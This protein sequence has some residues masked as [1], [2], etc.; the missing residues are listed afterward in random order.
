MTR[1]PC[2][3]TEN[4]HIFYTNCNGIS[5]KLSEI[6]VISQ[7]RNIGAICTTESHLTNEIFDAEISLPNFDVFR[8]DRA[9]NEKGG[10]SV[11][12]VRK[13]FSA[14]KLNWFHGTES[15][16]VK[17]HLPSSV[18]Y[19]VCVYRSPSHRTIEANQ[20]L[21]SQLANIPVECEKN[22]IVVGDINLPKVDWKQGIVIKPE[23]ST[24]KWLNMQSEFLD[25]FITK[26]FSWF[27]EEQKTRIRNVNGSLQQS[28]LDQVFTNNTGLVNNVEITA[29]LGKSDHVSMMVEV[30]SAINLDYVTT[31]R[32]NWYKVNKEFVATNANKINWG[33][34]GNI[35]NVESMWGELYHKILSISDLV[36][37]VNIKTDKSGDI[38]EKLPWDTSRL[39][40]KRKEKDQTWRE[41]DGNPSMQ[42]FQ[43][44]MYKQSEFQK[45]EFQEKLKYEKKIVSGLKLN[46]KPFFR[47]LRSK[48][49]LRKTVNELVDEDGNKT[50]SPNDTAEVLLNFFQSVF[51]GESFGPLPEKCFLD[52][53][54]TGKVMENL[55]INPDQVKKL[56]QK[57]N[58][59]KAI[60][61][62]GLHPK[63]LKYL[64][65]DDNFV[66]ALT[67]L[68]KR[69]VMEECIPEIWKTAVVIPIHK[70]GS[71]H[72]PENYRP[73]SLTCILCKLYETILREHILAFVLGLITDKQHGFLN[74]K[75]CL[76]NL[77][78]TL[79]KA[80]EYM[81]EGNCV[82][83]LYFDFSKAFD[84]VSHYRLLVKLQT[85]GVSEN[86]LNIIRNFLGNRTM[87]VRVGDAVSSAKLVTSG[88]PQ[89]SVLGPILFLLFINDLPDNILSMI[90]I[91]ADD[92]KMIVDPFNFEQTN[93]DLEELQMW[94][95]LWVLNFNIEKCKV[96]HIGKSN[97]LNPYK[98]LDA[99]LFTC[100]N[101][102]DLGVIFNNR[103]NFQDHIRTA[104]SK[105][106]S[107]L[108]WLLRNTLSR[109]T[110]V[111]KTA[112]K[113]LV[114]HNVEYCCQVWAPNNRHGNWGLILDIESIQRTFTRVIDG[115][116]NLNYKQRLE[117]LNMTTLLERRMRGDL[118]ETFK[119][120]N[121]FTKYGQNLFCKSSRTG[122][123]I[124]RSAKNT[125]IDFFSSRIIK[126]WN[127]LPEFVK[128][129]D[130]VN[131][132][133]NALDK[134]R[135]NGINNNLNGQF[136][137][138]SDEIFNRI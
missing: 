5:N 138:L 45:V 87:K 107:S 60:G 6:S 79:D 137:E 41:F 24:D 127:K 114:R 86:I 126:Y 90:K 56:L 59:N 115:M 7:N 119:I 132:F 117:K 91:F 63:L 65:E 83:L 82:D 11:I 98:F 39:V 105:A 70:K 9:T 99:D 112:Y 36:P 103:L 48:N 89:G 47:Y 93:I 101:E 28:T 40:R 52:K 110:Y 18:L 85:L 51:K 33:Y 34:S 81:A 44:A 95:S 69:C 64:A 2:R 128:D 125:N 135:T 109:D 4:F 16:A 94:E 133:K 78:E 67:M 62:D 100:E 57:L 13:Q 130:T 8:E 23:N 19:V 106:K 71:V 3:N 121:G 66:T 104:I 77:L 15:L 92:V 42:N 73:V 25:L 30:N 96:L 22:V 129:K 1:Q 31:K 108:A 61:P 123:L 118:I 46:T 32:K 17:V 84:T 35:T 50:K 21:L 10:G 116:D 113:A 102:K 76:S 136:W 122:N 29:P 120:L 58:E 75:S 97:P 26:G 53:N 43:I 124:Y 111:M 54:I 27:I 37:E 131:G 20:K 80:N 68:L 88:V 74:G 134:F 49:K 38:L 14:Q 12:F 55:E 72:Q